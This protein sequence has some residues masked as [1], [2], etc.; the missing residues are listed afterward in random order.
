MPRIRLQEVAE[1][2]GVSL[3]T[4]SKA[5]NGRADVAA[6]TRRLVLT[7]ARE[8]GWQP[9]GDTQRTPQLAVVFDTVSNFYVPLVL[10]GMLATA[11]QRG[12]SLHVT[13]QGSSRI[14]DH[15]PEAGSARWISEMADRGV[16]A[17]ILANLPVTAD[18]AAACDERGL[19]L[20][21][22]DPSTTP[23]PAQAAVVSSAN[24]EG[25]R[26]AVLHLAQLGHRRIGMITGPAGAEPTL[27]RSAG[28]RA[29]LAEVGLPYDE[30][31]VVTSQ[32]RYEGGMVAAKF[33]LQTPQRPTAIFA[34]CDEMALGVYE[35]SRR[36]GIGVPDELSVVGFD[37][38]FAA[39]YAAPPLTTVRQPLEEM[40]SSAVAAACDLL[41]GLRPQPSQLAT[42]LVVRA[43]TAAAGA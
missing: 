12:V 19:A 23:L 26:Q 16:A 17:V 14:D 3:A 4:A 41:E 9:R 11:R 32:F 30:D 33:L 31:L 7:T 36:L 20:V 15:Y 34:Q 29:A 28:Y 21:C 18:H 43:S 5:L 1:V 39:Q 24:F 8:L 35:A 37:D 10:E 6:D 42:R 2:A 27:A 22:V 13:S 25:G 40:G 38:G